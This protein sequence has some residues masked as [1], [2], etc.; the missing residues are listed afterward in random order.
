MAVDRD[1]FSAEVEARLAALPS[2]DV[3]RERIDR[4]PDAG[5]TIVATGPL[6]AAALAESIGFEVVDAAALQANPKYQDLAKKYGNPSPWLLSDEKLTDGKP[7]VSKTFA[8]EGMPA[9]FASSLGRGN[10]SQRFDAQ[11][12]GRGDKE[13]DI[14]RELGVTDRG[15]EKPSYRDMLGSP[16]PKN[17]AAVY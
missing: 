1:V 14:A 10:F 4:L 2:L 13:G 8:P 6:T 9:F 7:S 5:L 3:V 16:R 11:N 17:P 12:Q 15:K